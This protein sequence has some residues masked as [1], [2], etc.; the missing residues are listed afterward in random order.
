M[1]F[2]TK[3]VLLHFSLSATATQL[4]PKEKKNW[5]LRKRC[6]LTITFNVFVFLGKIKEK[7]EQK[8][9]DNYIRHRDINKTVDEKPYTAVYSYSCSIAYTYRT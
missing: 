4:Q 9:L 3:R 6:Y 8:T 1:L 5:L 2:E 7:K